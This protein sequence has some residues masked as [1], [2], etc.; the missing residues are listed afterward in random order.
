MK[1]LSEQNKKLLKILR[2]GGYYSKI[3]LILAV[4]GC[5]PLAVIPFYRS[6]VRYVHAFLLPVLIY[7]GLAFVFA[8]FIKEKPPTRQYISPV[9]SA[10]VP[11]IFA[12]GAAILL[13]ALPFV[14]G[15][16]LGFARALFESTSGWTTTGLTVVN[17]DELPAIFL[18]HRAFMQYAG[19][20]G[21]IVIMGILLEGRRIT[22]LYNAEGHPEGLMPNLR[23]TSMAIT[24]IYLVSLVLGTVAYVIAKMPVFDA[25]CH[26]MSALSTAGFSTRNANIGAYGSLPVELISIVLMLIGMTNFA[27]LLLFASLRLKRLFAMTE[28]R[29]LGKV[30]LVTIPL[31]A[32]SLFFSA[33]L[34]VL[35]SIRDSAFAVVS[36]LS[37][38]GFSTAD[39]SVY[40]AF[41]VGI[42]LILM[43][44]GGMTGSTAGG[45]KLLRTS[46]LIRATKA[47][48]AKR[49]SSSNKVT[50]LRYTRPNGAANIDGKLIYDTYEFVAVYLAIIVAGTLLV[51]LFSG[52]TLYDAFY[53]FTS[54]IGTIGVSNGLSAQTNVPT[55][56]VLIFGMILGRLE[57]Y[58]VFIG[59]A[60][61]IR[62]T[63]K[64][65][66][67]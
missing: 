51:T 62:R 25:I 50:V 22:G 52:A 45:I 67:K 24:L 4:L 33:K 21:F 28:V 16:R 37:T 39:Y 26:T 9:V 55:L 63:V 13:G 53:E 54:A 44:I 18:L 65:I 59:I 19:G 60:E 41:A 42:S 31:T 27:A 10:S 57:M 64:R 29:F 1:E 40:P 47:N 5:V 7:C 48:I 34:G 43:I 14:F 3:L 20:L 35:R 17:A 58:I 11:V 23:R 12:W 8:L 61:G 32:L 49:L 30:L 36:I 66:G 38:T 2:R 46:V 56:L 6:D 15:G